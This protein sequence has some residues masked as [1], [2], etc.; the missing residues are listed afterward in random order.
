MYRIKSA[1]NEWRA[2]WMIFWL[3]IV[4]ALTLSAGTQPSTVYAD[5][6]NVSGSAKVAELNLANQA[7]QG[8]I[9]AIQLPS[10]GGPVSSGQLVIGANANGVGVTGVVTTNI[11]ASSGTASSNCDGEPGPGIVEAHCI[12]RV[13]GL[14]LNLVVNV[15]GDQALTIPFLTAQVI[16]AEATSTGEGSLN[17]NAA[18]STIVGLQI[19]GQ[20]IANVSPG[21][22][23]PVNVTLNTVGGVATGSTVTSVL[24]TLSLEGLDPSVQALA[25]SVNALLFGVDEGLLSS[26]TNSLGVDATV[27]VSGSITLNDRTSSGDGVSTTGVDVLMLDADLT[28]S[29][30]LD[31]ALTSNVTVSQCGEV[32]P[33]V[34]GL[35]RCLVANLAG[36]ILEAVGDL[37]DT[38]GVLG[39]TLQGILNQ[40][41]LGFGQSGELNRDSNAT[42]NLGVLD[43]EIAQ[44]RSAIAGFMV[45]TP[46]P[47]ATSTPTIVPAT[48]T[49]T[50]T[51][52]PG[53]PTA[54]NTPRPGTPTA[55]NTP[56]PGAPSATNTPRPGTPTATN[57]PAPGS[58]ATNTPAPG[59]PTAGIAT[60]RPGGPPAGVATPRPPATGSA[61]ADESDTGLTLIWL[62]GATA[63]IVSAALFAAARGRRTS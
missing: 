3:A 7:I 28:V 9:G 18:G 8:G 34:L 44:A 15:L 10:A 38:N 46:P 41:G 60:P 42:V 52:G 51:P 43:F 49:A 6:G 1:F 40:L 57:T 24:N 12:S 62:V 33:G 26:A 47:G 59:G 30:A 61:V 32:F 54:T 13:E 22:T 29:I 63:V 35:T 21:T 19:N 45:S 17:S 58:F 37:I 55:T 39:T 11:S 36:S 2:G 48:P 31:L 23:I 14:A 53:S 5:N 50:N 4:A 27:S 56:R 20:P 16:Q 25:D